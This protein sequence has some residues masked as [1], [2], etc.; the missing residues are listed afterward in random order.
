MPSAPQLIANNMPAVIRHPH[1]LTEIHAFD[2]DPSAIPSGVITEIYEAG[3]V[4]CFKN[5]GLKMELDDWNFFNSL[6]PPASDDN[7]LKKAKVKAL[8]APVDGTHVL[9][10]LGL[11]EAQAERLRQIIKRV[12]KQLRDHVTRWFPTYKVLDDQSVTWRL[13]PTESEEIHYDSYGK[14]TDENHNVRVFVNLDSKPR[15]WGVGN[16]IDETIRIY[17]DR[18]RPRATEHPNI[19]NAAVNNLLPWPE[20]SRHFVTFAPLNMWLVNSQVVAHEIIYGRRMIAGTYACDPK[21]MERPELSFVN[22]V[23]KA[24][25]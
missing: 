25:A 12:T 4:V 17:R 14:G 1:V 23:R 13:T 21:T 2:C 8:L 15:L 7:W 24:W 16:P 10:K 18:L 6:N 19:F 5:A 11:S 3:H 22:R 20:V 9:V